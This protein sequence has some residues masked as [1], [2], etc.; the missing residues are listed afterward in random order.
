[1]SSRNLRRSSRKLRRSSRKLRRSDAAG[2]D[3]S[4]L[5]ELAQRNPPI[6]PYRS[7]QYAEFILGLRE[8][9][10][11][12]LLRPTVLRAFAIAPYGTAPQSRQ[13]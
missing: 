2:D 5:G 11:R 8:A 10:T 1:M 7:A 3:H 6:H 4:E 13:L 9:R 12:G